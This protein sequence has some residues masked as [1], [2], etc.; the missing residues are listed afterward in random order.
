MNK[1]LINSTQSSD[2]FSAAFLIPNV[3]APFIIGLAIGYFAKKM[4]RM[5][6]FLGAGAIVLLFVSEYY[7][8]FTVSDASL[9]HAA[10][11]ATET[12]QSSGSFLLHRLSSL[13]GKGISTVIGFYCGLKIG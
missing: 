11:V 2:I 12:A 9:Q 3:G 1:E 8:F 5:A 10:N 13:T 4:L 6:L 7:G